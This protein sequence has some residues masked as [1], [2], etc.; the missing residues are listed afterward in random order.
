ME[1]LDER[2]RLEYGAPELKKLQR[3]YSTIGLVIA[4]TLH[5]LGAGA[6]WGSVALTGNKTYSTPKTAGIVYDIIPLPPP[7]VQL[8]TPQVT[9]GGSKTRFGTPVPVPPWQVDTGVTFRG[10][11]DPDPTPVSFEPGSGF[12]GGKPFEPDPNE[13]PPPFVAVERLPE[14]VKQ[15]PPKYPELATRAGLEGT[16]WVRIWIDRE[17]KPKKAVVEKSDAEIFNQPAEEAA[18]RWVFTPAMMKNGPV[19]VWVSIPFRFKLQGK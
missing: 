17:G 18:M 13:P 5:F 14:A 4:L 3:K 15:V 12:G 8:V 6:Y 7:L 16:V 10:Q 1:Q 9:A 11:T 2:H 19:P